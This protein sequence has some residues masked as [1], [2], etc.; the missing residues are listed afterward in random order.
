MHALILAAQSGEA[1]VTEVLGVLAAILLAAK[2][3]GEVAERLGQ[4][5]VLGEMLAGVVLGPSV[6][7]LVD[8]SSPALH[9]MAEVGVVV[10]LFSIGLETELKRLLEVGGTSVMVALAG[11][12]LPFAGGFAVSLFLGLTN[13]QAIV[14]GAALTA[15]S[16]GITARVLGDLG[17]LRKPD[18]QVILGAAIV[19][20]V[21]GL[22]I[23][24]VVSDA[25][26]GTGVTLGRILVTTTIAFGFLIAAVVIGGRLAEPILRIAQ[27]GTRLDVVAAIGLASAFL[28]ALAAD[29]VGSAPI[30]GAFAAGLI[31]APTAHVHRVETHV[32]ALGSFFV[33]IFFVSVGAAVDLRSLIQPRT[34]LVGGLLLVVALVGKVA[35]GYAPWWYRGNRLLIGVGMVPRGEV[36]LIFAQ[37]GLALAV[38]DNA[39]FSALALVVFITTFLAPPLLKRLSPVEEEEVTPEHSPIADLVSEV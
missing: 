2:A 36:G 18:G 39:L 24:A 6:L 15:T 4:P 13:P 5:A 20:D 35:A 28:L 22:I 11:V 34:L 1:P 27:R 3:L 12:V 29:R 37:L 32:R 33:P 7:G 19:D 14:M 30:I 31:I 26:L 21:V 16:V 8:P 10:L 17:R 23:L 9:L 38:L 25:V